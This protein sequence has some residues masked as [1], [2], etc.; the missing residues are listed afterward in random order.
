MN[1]KDTVMITFDL[2]TSATGYTVFVNAIE[3]FGG[4]FDL[5]KRKISSDVRFAEMKEK[6]LNL[7]R[8]YKPQ[9]IV[10]ENPI[11]KKDPKA[12][13]MLKEL[14]GIV[15]GVALFHNIF[16]WSY[17]PSAWHKWAKDEDE[18]VPK[19]REELKR[20]SINKYKM[21]HGKEPYDD[22]HADSYL[23]GIAYVNQMNYYL[24]L[25]DDEDLELE[26]E[27]IE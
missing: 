5:S 22:N 27:D 17:V 19:T 2:S 24:M 1:K 21:A 25:A 6:I 7:I 18:Q 8:T 4:T 23:I 14:M 10:V 26:L 12:F 16:Y 11:Y 9:I 13:G 20:W 15:E 3:L